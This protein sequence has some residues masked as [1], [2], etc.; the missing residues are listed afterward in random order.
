MKYLRTFISSQLYI[1]LEF[2]FAW[3]VYLAPYNENQLIINFL[4]AVITFLCQFW[5]ISLFLSYYLIKSFI[6][7]H[8]NGNGYISRSLI[9]KHSAFID[10]KTWA[11]F[12]WNVLHLTFQVIFPC[13]KVSPGQYLLFF[14]R[15]LR[16]VSKVSL[17]LKFCGM[18][19]FQTLFSFRVIF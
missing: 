9:R 6:R 11:S 3:F 15:L 5:N 17:C 13:K 7:F 19:T 14:S 8:S 4:C 10:R 12:S 2:C 16:R 18:S 1:V